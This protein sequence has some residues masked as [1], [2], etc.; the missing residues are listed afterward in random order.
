MRHTFAKSLLLVVITALVTAAVML[1]PTLADRGPTTEL[2]IAAAPTAPPA[3][4]PVQ[5]S[6]LQPLML[7][8][9]KMG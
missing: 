5:Y 7:V 9:Q 3:D 1:L 6:W 4:P 2:S 8:P